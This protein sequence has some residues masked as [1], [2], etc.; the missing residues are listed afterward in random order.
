[1]PETKTFYDKRSGTATHVVYCRNSGAAAV[2]DPVFD[3]D[4]KSGQTSRKPVEDVAAFIRERSLR[5]EWILET[6]VHHDHI[7]GAIALRNEVGGKIAIGA[8]V[9][10]VADAIASVYGLPNNDRVTDCFD[11]LLEDDEQIVLGDHVIE[12]IAT[13]GHTIDHVS[14]AVGDV[15]FA[16]DTLFMPDSGT[17]R[18]DFHRGSP[19]HLFYSIQRI[20]DRPANVRLFACHDYGAGGKREAAWE[21]TVGD[22][23]AHNIHIGGSRSEDEFVALRRERDATLSVPALMLHALPLNIQAGRLPAPGANGR[24]MLSIPLD[25]PRSAV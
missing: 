9:D 7:S 22:Q 15:L 6:H 23:R 8:R 1:M 10:D 20:L 18:C 14:Y 24:V 3:L 21:S 4:P 25:L 12:V 13:P 16:G 19:Q 2:I 17:A 11:R 5:L